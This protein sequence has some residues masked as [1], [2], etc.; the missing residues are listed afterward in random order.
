MM[1]RRSCHRSMLVGVIVGVIHMSAF[2]RFALWRLRSF[3]CVYPEGRR[4]E[5]GQQQCSQYPEIAESEMHFTCSLI[6][7]QHRASCRNTAQ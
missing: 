4:K 6:P 7:Q 1:P 2:Y 5:R 3:A